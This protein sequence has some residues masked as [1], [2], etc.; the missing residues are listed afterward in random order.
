MSRLFLGQSPDGNERVELKSSR[1]TTHGVV[2][3]MTGS[4][5][6]G[7][8]LVLLE[9]LV[10]KGVPIVAID[11][12]GDLGNLGLVFPELSATEFAPWCGSND[13][14]EVA[15]GWSQGIARSGLG[16]DDV[17]SLRERMDLVVHTPGSTSGVPVNVLASLQAPQGLDEEALRDLVADTVT[18]LLGLVGRR[19]DPV[20]DPAHVVMSHVLEAAWSDGVDLDLPELVVRLVDPPFKKVGIFPV[21]KFFPPDDRM[22]L[23]M[24][25]NAVL[26]S[27]SFQVWSRGPTLDP[28]RLFRRGDRTA[29]SVFALAHLEET[30]RQF[31]VS[32]LLSKILSWSR[33]QPGTDELRALVFFD[34]VAGYLPPHP[35]QPPTK[36]P[37]LTMMKQTRAVGVGV[38]L[39]TQNP[40]DLDYK[41]LSN[42]GVWAIGRLNTEQDRNR[43]LKG[44]DAPGLD[45]EVARLEKRQFVL[46]Q[47]GRGEPSVLGS[48]HAMCY[49]RGPL[50]RVEFA[51]LNRLHGAEVQEAEETGGS[52]DRP[53]P[54]DDGLLPAPPSVEGVDMAF[55]DPRVAFAA[56]F[57]GHFEA[58]SEAARADG[59][60]AFAP[61]LWADLALRFDEDRMGFM[62]DVRMHRV[63]YPLGETP[64]DSG[65]VVEF[66]PEDLLAAA[67]ENGRYRSLPDWADSARELKKLGKRAADEVYRTE[68]DGM[69]VHKGLKLYGKTDESRDSF[70]DR[71]RQAIRERID[72]KVAKLKDR[73]ESKAEKLDDKIESKKAKLVE[74]EGV[75]KSRQLEEAVNVGATV[76]SYLGFGRKRNLTSAVSRRRQSAQAARRVDSLE[77]EIERLEDDAVALEEELAAD[78]EQIETEENGL[79]DQ[80][81]EREVRLEKNDIQVLRFGVLWIPVSR[82]VGH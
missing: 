1:L 54:V 51:E 13:P 4:G 31:F 42:A 34:E 58:H 74:L 8:S 49:L 38:V 14:T 80:V 64:A 20:K 72:A 9:E 55:L 17:R 35:K 25:F 78:I 19:A 59:K 69:F 67:P 23:A 62:R 46:H 12:K 40:V 44:I 81:Q 52:E 73:Y 45:A 21:D 32:L 22:E 71:C 41:A 61:A 6:T 30:E 5:K 65:R 79:L 18:G 36:G 37:L 16:P 15:A 7:L 63:W 48:R 43:L 10:L 33:S 76:L 24:A 77:T 50:T 57:D 66:E 47:V 26:A 53:K 3:G 28:E 29:V 2:V 82:R 27:P 60:V 70:E 75:A 11:P 68:T 39:S 56:R